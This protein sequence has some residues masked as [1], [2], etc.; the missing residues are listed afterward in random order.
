MSERYNG[1]SKTTRERS[2]EASDDDKCQQEGE[3]KH[4]STHTQGGTSTMGDRYNLLITM[5]KHR[6]E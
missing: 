5:P 6:S 2:S 4:D 1:M 3:L